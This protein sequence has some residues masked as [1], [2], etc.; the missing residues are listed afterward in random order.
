MR[1]NK[2]R[3]EYPLHDHEFHEIVYISAGCANHYI[4]GRIFPMN[5]GYLYFIRNT[6]V[7]TYSDFSG[8]NFEYYTLLFEKNVVE[9]MLDF[10]GIGKKAEKIFSSALPP[11]IHLDAANAEKADNRFSEVFMLMHSDTE[12][13]RTASRHLLADLFLKYFL[14]EEKKDGEIPLWL[15]YAYK[16][17]HN[18]K[19]FTAGTERFFEICGRRREHCTRMLKKYYGI[20]PTAYVSELRMKYAAVL[21]SSG[22]LTVAQTAYECGY[23]S[24]PHFY[25]MFLSSF[26]ISPGEYR[27]R[28]SRTI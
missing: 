15:E 14:K 27:D 12:L 10:F 13:F 21:L 7:H 22:D 5:G 8:E 2:P 18:P 23:D 16:K 26:G 17:M 25:S 24:I 1:Y 11:E 6:D 28:N 3:H 19:N 4:N 20:T 9:E